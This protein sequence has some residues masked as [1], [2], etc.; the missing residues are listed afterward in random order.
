MPR[1]LTMMATRL[2]AA[3]LALVLTGSPVVTTACQAA[4]AARESAS[5]M[6]GEHHSCHREAPSSNGPALTGTAHAC[7]HS[8]D[9]PNA[10][11]QSLQLF[12]TPAVTV[13]TFSLMPPSAD[14]SKGGF[15]RVEPS[16][17]DLLALNT[18]LR[19]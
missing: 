13:A 2:W 14:A 11:D 15:A 3:A 1:I 7:G 19:V 16:P 10:I 18:Q 5:A 12:A 17:P 4:C 8:N 6:M 9:S